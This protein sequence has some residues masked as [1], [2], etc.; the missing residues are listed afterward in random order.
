MAPNH[1][2]QGQ[3]DSSREEVGSSEAACRV[4]QIQ[5][6][7]REAEVAGTSR[8]SVVGWLVGDGNIKAVLDS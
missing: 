7:L 1:Q 8:G 3:E 4:H 2:N 5:E 6:V